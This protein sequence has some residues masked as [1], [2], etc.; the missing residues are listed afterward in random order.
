MGEY[1]GEY[2]RDYSAWHFALLGLLMFLWIFPLWRIIEKAGYPPFIS[3]LAIFPV[4][5]LILL[6]W[7]AFSRWPIGGD[8]PAIGSAPWESDRSSRPRGRV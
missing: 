6:W 8:R 1:V 2:L 3:L 4:V 5:G 7:L